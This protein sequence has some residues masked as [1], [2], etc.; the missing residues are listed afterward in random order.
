MKNNVAPADY[1]HPLQTAAPGP[2]G[3]LPPI[4]ENF[5]LYTHSSLGHSA[6]DSTYAA[7]MDHTCATT[8]LGGDPHVTNIKG[9]SFD[10]LQA[11]TFK[12]LSLQSRA[13]A[14][15]EIFLEVNTKISRLGEECS[16]A[17]IEQIS[18]SG[19]WLS[20]MGYNLVEIRGKPNFIEIGLNGKWYSAHSPRFTPNFTHFRAST[21]KLI[22]IQLHAIAINVDILNFKKKSSRDYQASA[23]KLG[24]SF[25]NMEFFGLKRFIKKNPAEAQ[26]LL[27][28]ED[29]KNAARA[30]PGCT[31]FLEDQDAMPFLSH[32]VLNS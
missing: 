2:G 32:I 18:L 30:P 26:G 23:N 1:P 6:V 10:I 3:V 11:G 17:Y 7:L 5:G 24:W 25:L 9:E 12:M 8:N 19:S 15:T 28:N 29:H 22:Q 21:P 14:S 13:P 16:E 4:S 20:K 27:G 31:K